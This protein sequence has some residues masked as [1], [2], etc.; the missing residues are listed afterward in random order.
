MNTKEKTIETSLDAIK[1]ASANPL[2]DNRHVDEIEVGQFVRQGDVYIVRIE[3]VC[4]SNKPT[5]NRQLAP[6]STLGSRHTVDDAVEVLEPLV[7]MQRI[8][9]KR[10]LAFRGPQI[11]SDTRFTVSHP[12]HA[13]ISLPAGCYEVQF[14]SDWA[15]QNRAR[16]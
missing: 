12:E 7:M 9:S 3:A 5:A 8:E 15:T 4:A 13:D 16:D 14:Q 11:K 10:G 2:G 1:E 6:G